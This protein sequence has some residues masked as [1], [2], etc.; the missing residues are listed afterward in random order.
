M[1]N[2]FFLVALFAFNLNAKNIESINEPIEFME[3]FT[4]EFKKVNSSELTPPV[5]EEILKQ[6]PTSKLAAVYK[7]SKNQFKLIMVLQSGT[8]RTVYIDSY[9]RWFKLK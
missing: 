1:K 4:D 5:V 3:I 9:G 7:N 8:R 2:I 6:Y